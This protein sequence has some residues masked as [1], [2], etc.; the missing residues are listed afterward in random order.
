MIGTQY[1]EN[2]KFLDSHRKSIPGTMYN[3]KFIKPDTT[4]KH[5]Q[6]IPKKLLKPTRLQASVK[7]VD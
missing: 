3:E 2:A 7:L 4:I 5:I 1:N 6:P